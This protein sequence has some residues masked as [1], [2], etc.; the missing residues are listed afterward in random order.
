MA[1]RRTAY[2]VLT[3]AIL[4]LPCSLAL[5]AY[6]AAEPARGELTFEIY[7]DAKKEYRW[8]LK[9]GNGKLIGMSDEG[10]DRK[11]SCQRVIELI[12]DGAAKAR[13]EDHSM[14]D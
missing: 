14:K 8:R 13:V 1:M 2:A 4:A 9:S 12:K 11:D 3:A 6:E 7:K 10:Y 5:R